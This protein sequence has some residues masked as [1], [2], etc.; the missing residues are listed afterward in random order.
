MIK[1][2]MLKRIHITNKK[3]F[4]LVELLGVIILLGVIAT[5]IAPN[6]L[7]T[8]KKSEKEL[9]EDSVNAL[10]R[11]AQI[12]Y[13]NNDFINY[14]T[15]GIAANSK[16]LDVKNNDDMTSGSIKLVND[17]Y[18]YA[19]NVSNGKYCANGVRNDLSIDEGKCP[20]TPD[21]CF[22]FDKSTGTITKFYKEKVGCDIANPTV[23]DKIDGIVVKKIGQYAFA[24]IKHVKCSKY[25][26]EQSQYDYK[27]VDIINNGNM[28]KI[29][30]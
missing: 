16:E 24:N 22:G 2:L 26:S 10:I 3:G 14:P 4:T 20:D 1:K 23:P 18:F 15:S 19:T 30:E 27:Y 8:Q 29:N 13:A 17:E 7:K 6:I 12:Y 9:F 21:R 25:I 28:S 5:I 11:G